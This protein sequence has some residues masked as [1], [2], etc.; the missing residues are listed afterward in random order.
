MKR[1]LLLTLAISSISICSCA[2]DIVDL[3]GDIQGIVKDYAYGHMIAN[4]QVSLMPSG[5]ITTTDSQGK[6]SFND[7]EAGEYSVAFSKS[8]YHDESIKI[9]VISGQISEASILLKAKSPF[10]LSE[11]VIDFGDLESN[12]TIYLYNNTDSDCSYEITNIPYWLKTNTTQGTLMAGSSSVMNLSVDRTMVDDGK[13]SQVLVFNYSGKGTG[14]VQAQVKFEKVK[15]GT[16]SV[17][18][19]SEAYNITESSFDIK[20]EILATG[21]Q[22][23]TSHG[24][25]WSL[26]PNPTIADNKKE[27][28][29]T[30]KT[31]TF[32][33]SFSDLS[34]ATTYYVRAYAVN[35]SGTSYSEQVVVKTIEAGNEKWDGS[36]EETFAGGTGTSSNPYIIMTGGHLLL[37]SSYPNK[38]YALANNID[39]NNN[40]WKPFA[41]TG[42]LD[43]RGYTISNLYVERS[44][45]GQG[46]VSELSDGGKIKNLTIEGVKINA[47]NSQYVGGIV[48]Y[49]DRSAGGII[50]CKVILS[51]DSFINGLNC[52][53]G[54]VG[55]TNVKEYHQ[56]QVVTNCETLSNCPEDFVILGEECVGGIIGAGG[57]EECRVSA[58]IHGGTNVG[59]V[60]GAAG[61]HVEACSFVGVIEGC[62]NVGGVVGE[63]DDFDIQVISSKAN[64]D[65]YVTGSRAGGIVGYLHQRSMLIACYADGKITP[66]SSSTELLGGL[67]G[68]AQYE[69]EVHHSY[70]TVYSS[71]KN[72]DGIASIPIGDY[73]GMQQYYATTYDSCTTQETSVYGDNIKSNCTDI[74]K[75]M[76]E[77]YSS[78]SN[79]WDYTSKW[80]WTGKVNGLKKTVS[81]P[82]LAWE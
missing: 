55:A 28:G 56:K 53:G 36:K 82:M 64:A 30:T 60:C 74:A 45:N 2:K 61:N 59:G 11:E 46:L 72:F 43:G 50:D 68:S 19:S 24:H 9:T 4:C 26:N 6:Y 52:V 5:K 54:I 76:T 27:L 31:G 49:I 14:S 42:T 15:L 69:T 7:I 77:C 70:S 75:F 67:I 18:C 13:Y 37:M 71:S 79:L 51:K 8:G 81:C 1:L 78:Y 22:T 63:I 66:E 35:A 73:S 34:N 20:G 3:S 23:I 41:F 25:C 80:T 47:P 16:P 12:K 58:N 39:L 44:N 38:C 48:G 29:S 10:A 33:S 62:E 17:S 65:I 32:V 21:G 57:C 40:N